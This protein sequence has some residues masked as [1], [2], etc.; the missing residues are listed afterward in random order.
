[1]LEIAVADY[2]F[3]ASAVN[4][5]MSAAVPAVT[6]AVR[7]LKFLADICAYPYTRRR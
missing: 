3:E 7:G 4:D 1:M 2:G 6:V 5:A